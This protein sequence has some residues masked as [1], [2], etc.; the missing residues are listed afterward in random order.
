MRLSNLALV[1]GGAASG[2]SAFAENH[3]RRG[4]GS[5][6]YIATAVPFDAEMK[7][8]IAQHRISRGA[9]WITI[10]APVDVAQALADVPENEAVLLDCATL[11]LSNL[12]HAGRDPD[13]EA[14][15]LLAAVARHAGPVTI[16]S[17]EVGHGIV[18]ENRL[19]RQFRGAQGRLNQQI[20]A[21]ASLVVVVMA[22]LPLVLKGTL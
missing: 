16:V 18:P 12:L 13:A 9:G 2:K 19:A 7:E 8:K 10:E 5:A 1:L 21:Q 15:A 14:T 11:W 4:G 22:G 3:A 17:N 20:A 6:W